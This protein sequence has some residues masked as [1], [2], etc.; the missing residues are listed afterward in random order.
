MEGIEIIKD[1]TEKPQCLSRGKGAF[2][3]R[4]LHDY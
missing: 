1:R 4:L 3:E 2:M